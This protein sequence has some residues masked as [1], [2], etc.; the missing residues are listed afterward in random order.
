MIIAALAFV[1]SLGPVGGA[2]SHLSAVG[3]SLLELLVRADGVAVVEVLSPTEGAPAAQTR[4]RT[5]HRLG[6][7]ELPGEFALRNAPSPMRYT[8][9]QRAIVTF[10]R[11]GDRW[12][13][14]QLTGEGIVFDEDELDSGTIAYV[15]D[16]WTATHDAAPDGDLGLL[17]R[18]GLRLPHRKLRVLA[19][20]DIAEIAHH[21]PGLSRAART[22]LLRDLED[23]KLD[24]DARAPLAQALD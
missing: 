9:G 21:Q 11:D 6:G 10:T 22:A 13:A 1:A 3:G 4:V 24:Q 14:T 16:L 15:T 8:A 2:H 12:K 19:A 23:P 17:L 18:R 20:L 7:L 5:I